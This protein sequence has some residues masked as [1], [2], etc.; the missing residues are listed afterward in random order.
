MK[1]KFIKLTD[2]YYRD[3]LML[4]WEVLRKPLGMPPGSELQP[5]EKDSF[6]LIAL[7]KKQ[8][9]GCVLF[10]P[11]SQTEGKIF[12]MA[13]SEEYRG[14]GFGRKLIST[15]EQFLVKRGICHLHV[16]ARQEIQGFFS[17]LGYF[18]EGDPIE[19]FGSFHQKMSKHI[20]M[21]NLESA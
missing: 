17:S 12:Q 4:R 15:L 11:E 8:L 3:E 13:L 19:R 5:E 7:E 10:H 16:F 14:Q 9:V 20:L 1:F 21:C 18:P 2:P 6:H